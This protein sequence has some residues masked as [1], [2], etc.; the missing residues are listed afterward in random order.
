M[1]HAVK[2]FRVLMLTQADLV[3]PEEAENEEQINR[4]P[5]RTDYD[6][7]NALRELGHEVIVS[8]ADASL[9]Q[10]RAELDDAK[11]DI[12]FNLLEMFAQ[13]SE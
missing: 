3:P 13:R 4:A 11:P 9:D 10:L 2:P 12:V 8:G 1:G 5:W 6:V 7:R